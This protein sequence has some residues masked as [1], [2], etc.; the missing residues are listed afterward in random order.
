[1]FAFVLVCG[2]VILLPAKEKEKG[3]FHLP[4]INA[5][6]IFPWIVLISFALIQ[7]KW[8]EF[9]GN[10]FNI[11]SETAEYAIPMLVFFGV[12]IVLGVYSYLR[13]F[14]LIP[15]LGL[16]SCC[17]LLTGMAWSNWK[18]FFVWM[19]IGLIV[20]F[21]YGFKKSKLNKNEA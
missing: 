9:F 17:Y 11:T 5:K 21:M 14:S 12:C 13:N 15:V 6:Y 8:P 1:L 2:G 4:Y 3:K 19:M 18:W 7:Y 20:Y 10:L 16:V